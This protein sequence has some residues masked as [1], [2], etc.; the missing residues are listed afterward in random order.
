MNPVEKIN[1]EIAVVEHQ[2][3]LKRTDERVS[4]ECAEVLESEYNRL[5]DIR[6]AIDHCKTCKPVAG[7]R[8]CI[9]CQEG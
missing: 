7:L 2:L 4:R 3:N 6:D 8:I 9:Q 1:N 5:V